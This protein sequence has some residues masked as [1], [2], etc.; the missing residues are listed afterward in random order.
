MGCEHTNE[1]PQSVGFQK[2]ERERTLIPSHFTDSSF[3]H[4]YK[5]MMLKKQQTRN[6]RRSLILMGVLL[7]VVSF[8]FVAWQNNAVTYYYSTE[9]LQDFSLPPSDESLITTTTTT[10]ADVQAILTEDPSDQSL[11]TTATDI[12]NIL[13]KDPFRQQQE[14][15]RAVFYNIYGDPKQNETS[16]FETIVL[17]Q[18]DQIGKS[19]AAAKT[20]VLYYNTVGHPFLYGEAFTWTVQQ[21]C[22]ALGL[23]CV[24]MAHYQRGF[25]EI[26]L[27]DVYQFCTQFPDRQ[28]IYF[29]NKVRTVEINFE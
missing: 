9:L 13:T 25:E 12:Q 3:F 15:L 8:I 21:K 1:T 17:E 16:F 5:R 24:H 22:Q 29:H 11:I 26:T 18:I 6:R 27:Q 10:T 14:S 4:Y 28:I 19:H 7:L 20:L 2:R 23:S